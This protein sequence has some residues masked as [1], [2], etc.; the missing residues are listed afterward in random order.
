MN[1]ID[2]IAEANPLIGHLLGRRSAADSPLQEGRVLHRE[3]D[4]DYRARRAEQGEVDPS[5]PI[6]FQRFPP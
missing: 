4:G 6:V 3:V 5:L 2:A 1:P